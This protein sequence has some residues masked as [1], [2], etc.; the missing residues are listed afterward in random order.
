MLI[1]RGWHGGAGRNSNR[2]EVA[3]ILS[4]SAILVPC[5]AKAL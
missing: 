2:H 1:D 3:A 5:K 4:D